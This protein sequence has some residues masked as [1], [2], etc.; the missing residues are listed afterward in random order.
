[1]A[2]ILVED[3][4]KKLSNNERI[5]AEV[6]QMVDIEYAKARLNHDSRGRNVDRQPNFD[7]NL[8]PHRESYKDVPLW[9]ALKW[10]VDP[11]RIELL[12]P[13]GNVKTVTAIFTALLAN[14]DFSR[15]STEKEIYKAASTRIIKLRR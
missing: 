7:N 14:R 10:M 12:T 3:D 2:E 13:A 9:V 1:M 6:G 4:L 15:I 11:R 8:N 5:V